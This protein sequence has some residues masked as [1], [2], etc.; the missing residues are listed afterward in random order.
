VRQAAKKSNKTVSEMGSEKKV[1]GQVVR[2][3]MRK[4]VKQAVTL[5]VIKYGV[6]GFKAS[7]EI[8][9]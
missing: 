1:V 5:E 6:T 8:G 9:S 2:E 4:V 7:S 3:A